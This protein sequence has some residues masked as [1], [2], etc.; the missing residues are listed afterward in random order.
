MIKRILLFSI[1]LFNT[2]IAAHAQLESNIWYFGIRAGIS[3]SNLPPT[4]LINGQMSTYEGC[5][6]ICDAN[7]NLQFYTDGSTVWNKT[8]QIMDNGTALNGSSASSQS[9]IIL[10]KPSSTSIYYVFT[11]D[12][13][14]NNF[15]ANGLE[16]SV[17]DISMNGGLGKVITKNILLINPTPEKLTVAKHINNI[18]YWVITHGI[19]SNNFYSFLVSPSGINI[20][21]VISSV[22][23]YQTDSIDLMGYLKVSNNSKKLASAK[24]LSGE[25]AIFDF[26]NSNGTVSNALQIGINE[27]FY[28][29]EFSPDNKKLYTSIYNTSSI[30]RYDLLASNIANSKTIIYNKPSCCGG[31][32]QIGLDKKIYFTKYGSDSLS[33]INNPDDLNCNFIKNAIYLN[34]K[35]CQ[36]G[37]PNIISSLIIKNCIP[38]VASFEVTDSSICQNSKVNFT[39]TTIIP[40][41]SQKWLINGQYFSSAF[42][43]NYVFNNAGIFTVSLIAFNDSCGDTANLKINVHPNKQT[44]INPAICQGEKYAVGIHDYSIA[45]TYLDTLLS[46]SGCDSIV[47]THL[48]FKPSPVINLGND[49]I[50][51][52]G[53]KFMLNASTNNTT[54]LWQDGTTNPTYQV[55]KEGLYRVI[56]TQEGCSNS[57]SINIIFDENCNTIFIPN[58]FLPRGITKTFK[59]IGSFSAETE[60]YFAIYNKWGQ[61][62]FETND[63]NIGWDG[64]YQNDVVQSGVYLYYLKIKYGEQIKEIEKTG[65]FTLI[66]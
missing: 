4:A 53:N 32:L 26:N 28:G 38:P 9:S 63:Y 6:T 31:A 30:Y 56:I 37:L 35:K 17:V 58:A 47:T 66:E 46:L 39:N 1:I 62:L 45:G 15:G 2:F 13:Q 16:Y 65:T 7:G 8:H 25:L 10:P 24:Y 41:T 49:T 33:V 20:T 61:L 27:K 18:D 54:Y 21:P 12:A 50:L 3:F 34:G 11:V 42:D 60:L 64:K 14:E 55:E 48:S 51:C 52:L 5:A 23:S 43:T 40:F 59:P 19:E 22:G 29:I 36:F 44:T 57:D